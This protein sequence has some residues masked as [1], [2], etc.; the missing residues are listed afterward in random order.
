[1]THFYILIQI[2]YLQTKNQTTHGHNGFKHQVLFDS[3]RNAFHH[4]TACAQASME[5]MWKIS[6][7]QCT[8]LQLKKSKKIKLSHYMP[9]RHMEGEEV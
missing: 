7:P 5:L 9:W 3:V 2:S 1:M 4:H 8:L 6:V